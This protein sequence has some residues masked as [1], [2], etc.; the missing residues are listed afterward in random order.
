MDLRRKGMRK[1]HVMALVL[2]VVAI[3][4]IPTVRAA[5]EK[6]P[7]APA[8]PAATAASATGTWKWETPGRNGGQ[9]MTT[10]LKL[11]QD[12]EKLTGTISGRNGT[13]TEI[14]DGKITKD[15][16]LSFKVTR[17][18]QGNE[19][20]MDYSGKLAGDTIKGKSEMTMNGQARTREFEA[21]REK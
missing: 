11:K 18:M 1:A 7:A 9:P 5:D 10:T 4:S 13:E 6:A 12:G 14:K 21:K 8:A 17:T 2:A 15:G 16:D 20:T 3:G 19:M